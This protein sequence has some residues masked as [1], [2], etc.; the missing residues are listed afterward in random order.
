MAFLISTS[1][2]ELMKTPGGLWEWLILKVFSFIG[3]YGWRIVF[4]TLCLK[5]L[6]VPLDIYQRVK[7]RKNQKITERIKP[8]IEALQKQYANDPKMLSQK[9]MQ[10]QKS[11]GFSYFSSCLPMIVTLVIFFYLFSGLNNIS[12]Y[13]NLQ[14]YV[15]LYDAYTTE[16]EVL[17][18]KP[19][20]GEY[21][22]AHGMIYSELENKITYI[23]EN[24][25][26]PSEDDYKTDGK[27]DEAKGGYEMYQEAYNAWAEETGF[28]VYVNAK[29]DFDKI[30]KAAA[31]KAVLKRYNEI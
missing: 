19:Y 22:L 26:P 31:E 29:S 15:E 11:E 21:E 12:R 4:F 3:N 18:G 16:E 20:D 5:I 23:N 14:Q 27:W 9:Q 17:K 6:L 25:P 8:Q 1:F 13:K 30:I 24:N 7:M 28:L 2:A 10:L